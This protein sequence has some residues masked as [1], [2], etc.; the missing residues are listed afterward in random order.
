MGMAASRSRTNE[1]RCHE[2]IDG[3]I[4]RVIVGQD[5]DKARAAAERLAEERG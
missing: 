2:S 1:D 3:M 5:I 4:A